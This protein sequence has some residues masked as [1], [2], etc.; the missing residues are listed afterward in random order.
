M[1]TCSFISIKF[2]LP[3]P[4]KIYHYYF[5]FIFYFLEKVLP[6][7]GEENIRLLTSAS[8]GIVPNILLSLGVYFFVLIKPS[9][10]TSRIAESCL[11]IIDWKIYVKS[12]CNM[13]KNFFFPYFNGFVIIYQNSTCFSIS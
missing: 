9:F 6:Q 10:I 4:K 3:I 13:I 12:D 2:L 11:D 5:V 1:N 8:R 7:E